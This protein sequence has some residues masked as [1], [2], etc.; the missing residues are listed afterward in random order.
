MFRAVGTHG[1]ASNPSPVYE[2]ELYNDG[3]AS[4]PIVK[5]VD[6][7]IS[8]HRTKTK[9]FRNLLRIT[10]KIAQSAVNEVQSGLIREDGTLGNAI[11]KNITLGLEDESL[12]G[13]KFKIRL[14]SKKTGK[15][16]DLN[17]SFKT[18]TRKT[19]TESAVGPIGKGHVEGVPTMPWD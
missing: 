14:T 13:K 12:F 6:I 10:P 5:I 17:I 16:I 2:I 7:G 18:A 1:E 19:G 3:G 4:Y 15:K 11:A 8:S 9:S